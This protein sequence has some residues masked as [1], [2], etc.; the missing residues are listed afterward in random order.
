MEVWNT[1]D[2]I[3]L[4][5]FLI[6][7]IRGFVRGFI[8]QLV[9]FIGLFIAYVVAYLF[10]ARLAPSLARIVPISSWESYDQYE[11]MIHSFNLDTYFYNALA[12]G[13]IFFVVKIGLS[14]VAYV[15][16]IIAKTPGLNLLNKC[17]GL[18]LAFVESAVIIIIAVNVME[19]IPAEGLQKLVTHSYIVD[20]VH[21]MMP[22]IFDKLQLLWIQYS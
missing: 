16:N 1:L 15:L 21:K 2:W 11:F 14:I 3:I 20:G 13:I 4:A 7:L 18:M 6:W 22:V 10:Y 12:F 19:A 17:G 8:S 9:S 5:F